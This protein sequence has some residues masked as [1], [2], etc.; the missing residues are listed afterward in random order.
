MIQQILSSITEVVLPLG[1]A[2]LAAGLI[3][4]HNAAAK[5]EVV[6][7]I[8]DLHKKVGKQEHTLAGMITGPNQLASATQVD[9]AL[10]NQQSRTIDALLLAGQA[11]AEQRRMAS[12]NAQDPGVNRER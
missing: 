9:E 1:S 11:F 12:D 2:L 10:R 7:T 6:E 3:I 8:E 5:R 4:K